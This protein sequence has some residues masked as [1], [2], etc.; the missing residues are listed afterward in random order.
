MEIKQVSSRGYKGYEVHV[1]GV[2]LGDVYPVLGSLN[3][4]T[5]TWCYTITA[6]GKVNWKAGRSPR[7]ALR[8][9][10]NKLGIKNN[11]FEQETRP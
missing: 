11:P 3:R 8:L 1:D 7:E 2:L 9:L 5:G 4:P 6:T 10:I